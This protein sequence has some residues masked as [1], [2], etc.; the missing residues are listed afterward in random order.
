MLLLSIKSEFE[1]KGARQSIEEAPQSCL[2]KNVPIVVLGYRRYTR[3]PS[4]NGLYGCWLRQAKKIIAKLT[5]RVLI[6]LE[7][8]ETSREG[9]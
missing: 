4:W 9:K 7:F 8:V 1:G 3:E 5:E 2:E 6:S